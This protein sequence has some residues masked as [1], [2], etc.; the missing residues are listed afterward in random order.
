MKKLQTL[1]TEAQKNKDSYKIIDVD[2]VD[3]KITKIGL[4]H[5]NLIKNLDPEDEKAVE[6]YANL[7]MDKCSWA[8]GEYI[9]F[10][11]EHFNRKLPEVVEYNGN[12][13]NINDVHINSQTTFEYNGKTFNF[14]PVY[15]FERFPDDVALLSAKYRSTDGEII[16]WGEMPAFVNT[17]AHKLRNTI[18][19]KG[20]NGLVLNDG[21]EILE[22]FAKDEQ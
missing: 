2:G 14:K 17:W 4:R 21:T 7:F 12:L 9:L 3:V 16:D 5:L 10:H 13:F 11:V 18:T 19:V 15:F 22:V 8:Q 1:L 6:K 20:S